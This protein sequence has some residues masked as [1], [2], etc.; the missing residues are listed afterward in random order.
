MT[1]GPRNCPNHPEKGA[2]AECSACGQSFCEECV[3]EVD[4][5]SFCG[6]C[7]DEHCMEHAGFCYDCV[8]AS[9]AETAGDMSTF[10]ACGSMFYGNAEKCPKCG[11]TI[12]TA[13]AVFGAFPLLPTGSYRVRSFET[14]NRFLSRQVPVLWRQVLVT[15]AVG[16]AVL[17]AA[18]GFLYWTRLWPFDKIP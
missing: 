15:W 4:E 5:T 10:N 16:L 7:A 2:E 1:D 6:P 11:S 8:A 18:I 3:R 17:G 13:W 14:E 12:R 9:S